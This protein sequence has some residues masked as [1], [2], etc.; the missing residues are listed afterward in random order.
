PLSAAGTIRR[1]DA[2]SGSAPRLVPIHHRR[3]HRAAF[4]LALVI[5]GIAHLA[6]LARGGFVLAREGVFGIVD[7][8]PL[9]LPARAALRM[10]RLFEEST[11]GAAP[12]RLAAALTRLGPTYV[13]LG[14]FLATR[15][16]VVGIAL[17]RDLETLQDKMA[18]FP[19]DQAERA[20][21]AAFDKPWSDIFAAFGPAVAAASIAQVHRAEVAGENGRRA[22]AVK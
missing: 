13:K 14:Q 11:T 22:V 15:P 9:P 2:R 21:E 20:I 4:G 3:H 12:N 10:A 5:A 8:A 19:Q 7:P 16:D 17:A 1:D 6:R 18:P